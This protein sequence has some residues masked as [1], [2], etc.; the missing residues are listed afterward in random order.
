MKQI[1]LRNIL[2]KTNDFYE[3]VT[4]LEKIIDENKGKKITIEDTGCY[5]E[6][7]VIEIED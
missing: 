5:E 3:V 1:M 4:E 2:S 6:N 7:I